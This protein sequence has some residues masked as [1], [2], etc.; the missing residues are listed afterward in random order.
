[1]DKIN[2]IKN[3]ENSKLFLYLCK[4]NLKNIAIICLLII[5]IVLFFLYKKKT[6]NLNITNKAI[7]E[8]QDTLHLYK[9]ADGAIG[10]TISVIEGDRKKLISLLNTSSNTNKQYK[11]IIDSLK[12]DK[13]IKTLSVINTITNTKYISKTDTLLKGIKFTRNIKDNWIDETISVDSDVLKRTLL[14]KDGYTITN[15]LKDN[16]GLFTGK[17]LTT[18]VSPKNP[19][20]VVTGITSIS[21]VIEKRKTRI[22]AF[23]GPSLSI[24]KNYNISPTISVGIGITF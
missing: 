16:K 24:D 22:G 11:E 2:F 21:T 13:N 12:K 20:T 6:E 4:M 15:K 5:S 8:L 1:M 18:Y 7:S 19:S 10:G 17:T 3:L 9:T 14:Y 23:I